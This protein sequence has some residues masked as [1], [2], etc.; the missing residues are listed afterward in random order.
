MRSLRSGSVETCTYSVETRVDYTILG[1]TSFH[2]FNNLGLIHFNNQAKVNATMI[3]MK[4]IQWVIIIPLSS[5]GTL[6]SPH[7][8]FLLWTTLLTVISSYSFSP[9]S[10]VVPFF[11]TQTFS[12]SCRCYTRQRQSWALSSQISSKD[13]DLSHSDHRK[14]AVSQSQQSQRRILAKTCESFKLSDFYLLESTLQ[15]SSLGYFCESIAFD[16]R[17]GSHLLSWEKQQVSNSNDD[18][19]N[20]EIKSDDYIFPHLSSLFRCQWMTEELAF[21]ET[22]SDLLNHIDQQQKHYSGKFI[23]GSW[24]LDYCLFCSPQQ[25]K[26]NNTPISSQSHT[27]KSLSLCIAQALDA[28]AA[29]DP[30]QASNHLVLMETSFGFSLTRILSPQELF[31][32]LSPSTI[33]QPSQTKTELIQQQ[34]DSKQ[35]LLQKWKNRPFQYS[36]AMN[37]NAADVIVDLLY[38]MV[39]SYSKDNNYE[40]KDNLTLLDPCC[41]CGTF[42]I[43]GRQKGMNIY[44]ID[45]KEKCVEGTM[46]NVQ[47]MFPKGND[48]EEDMEMNAIGSPFVQVCLGDSS[49]SII[50]SKI[51]DSNMLP[52]D[53]V[54]VNLPWGHNS[55]DYYNENVK[56]LT[57]LQTS[58]RKGTPC[59]FVSK[60][61]IQSDL[62]KLGFCV[63][64]IVSIPPKHF[65]LP[66]S[67]KKKK[68][69]NKMQD[70]DEEEP[71]GSGKRKS[72]SS[73]CMVTIAFSPGPIT[74]SS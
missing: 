14:Y 47:Y 30:K 71:L 56:I 72:T 50:P 21:G 35:T 63:Q 32:S 1:V 58:L 31:F 40:N 45:C 18:T 41:G 33:S 5:F 42:L 26:T 13:P 66:E 68:K 22:P 70:D 17:T 67:S 29:L 34:L 16:S 6:W 54:T 23:N 19:I 39:Q 51:I 57:C 64:G 49:Q 28:P 74:P 12:S 59:A 62:E 11:H 7:F 43:M 25:K 61:D 15:A 46:E 65:D 2:F 27:Q 24:S 10:S 55:V 38:S 37:P 36:S 48:E 44:G 52:P 20:G 53:M 8:L 4:L 9:S 60:K 73:D 3:I 69:K